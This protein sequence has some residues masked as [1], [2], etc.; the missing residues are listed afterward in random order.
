MQQTKDAIEE[1]DPDLENSK[2]GEEDGDQL[3]QTARTNDFDQTMR[4]DNINIDENNENNEEEQEPKELKTDQS[5]LINP[6][7]DDEQEKPQEDGE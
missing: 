2:E 7:N 4:T 5:I 1:G 6:N 3:N